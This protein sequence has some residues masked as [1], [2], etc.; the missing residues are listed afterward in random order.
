MYICLFTASSGRG[1]GTS[2]GTLIFR[3]YVGSVRFLGV[4]NFEFQYFWGVQKNEYFLGMTILWIFIWGH[5]KIGLYLG[6]ISMHFRGF[7]KIKVQNGDYFWGSVKY[8]IF[9]G[10][11]FG[12]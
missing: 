3:T 1:A 11:I 2:G 4:Q 7:L 10:D 12:G 6:V 9:L 5:H 8:Q